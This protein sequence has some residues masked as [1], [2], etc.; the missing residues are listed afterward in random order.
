MAYRS[1][2]LTYELAN[3]E[4]FDL[5]I[6]THAIL[7]LVHEGV[8]S[9][10]KAQ[11]M[12]RGRLYRTLSPLY[13]S[14]SEK[15]LRQLHFH[16][17]DGKSYLRFHKPDRY[18]D[19]LMEARPSIKRANQERKM[20]S[21]FEAGRVVS[22]YRY[23]YPLTH[24]GVFLGTVETSISIKAILSMLSR[25]DASKEYAFLVNKRLSNALLFEE[26]KHLSLHRCI[27]ASR[28]CD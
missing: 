9:E 11:S 16:L 5:F 14:L 2:G 19:D 6:N 23:V 8:T 22:G 18:G 20:V 27:V 13:E 24:R 12:A 10:G 21:V 26:Q 17:P 4:A 3:K 15:N 7:E 1:A 28:F 25:I